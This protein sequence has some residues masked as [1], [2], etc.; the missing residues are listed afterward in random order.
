MAR[1]WLRRGHLNP[2]CAIPTHFAKVPGAGSSAAMRP[3]G[4]TGDPPDRFMAATPN[5]KDRISL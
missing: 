1:F 3:D 5:C 4:L 2:D